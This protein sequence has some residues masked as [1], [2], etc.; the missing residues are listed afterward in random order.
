VSCNNNTSIGEE[1]DLYLAL[2][3]CENSVDDWGI[4]WS[5]KDLKYLI[6]NTSVQFICTSLGFLMEVFNF[7]EPWAS[8]WDKSCEVSSY[9]NVHNVLYTKSL[10]TISELCCSME[11]VHG[12]QQ[13]TSVS[14]LCILL[15]THLHPHALRGLRNDLT[16][17][18]FDFKE[19]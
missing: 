19:N 2:W 7:V 17:C 8:F 12:L 9:K 18:I 13:R 14:C 3:G 6:K 4:F 15:R 5:L 11:S 10:P 16:M 1:E